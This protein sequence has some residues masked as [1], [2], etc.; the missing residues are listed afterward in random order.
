MCV[1]MSKSWTCSVALFRRFFVAAIFI[2][3]FSVL[4]NTATIIISQPA[5]AAHVAR[6]KGHSGTWK[7]KPGVDKV[8]WKIPRKHTHTQQTIAKT[9]VGVKSG[10][11]FHFPFRATCCCVCGAG[12][13]K[14]CQWGY[15]L[16]ALF[17][18]FPSPYQQ[19]PAGIA[20]WQSAGDC[21]RQI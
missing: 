11:F 19:R 2:L 5:D 17:Y 8:L 15:V 9:K 12:D 4:H 14:S 6:A 13:W 20:Q 7:W 3:P 21:G 10:V 16:F 1:C 18:T